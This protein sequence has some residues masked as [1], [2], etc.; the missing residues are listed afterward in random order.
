MKIYKKPLTEEIK[1]II[2]NGFDEYS[3]EHTGISGIGSPICFYITDEHESIVSVIV[4]K[5]FWGAIH[6][7][8]LW[9]DKNHREKGYA[10][11]LM[12]AVFEYAKENNIPFAFLETMNFQA[13]EFYKKF[14]FKIEFER[15]GYPQNTSFI[16]MR[17]DFIK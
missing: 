8:S 10:S 16:Y 1:K 4:I 15:T 9:T 6:I 17:K 11:K 12:Q 13:P 5:M 3:E 14:G 7:K 2:H